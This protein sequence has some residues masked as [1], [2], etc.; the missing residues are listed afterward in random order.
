MSG[1]P[2]EAWK[3]IRIL[4]QGSFSHHCPL[5]DFTFCD[6]VTN[7]IAT[8]P[9]ANLRI[10]SDHVHRVHNCDDVP[11]HNEV[12]NDI[13]PRKTC[14]PIGD[15]PTYTEMTDSISEME[16]NKKLG[17]SGIPAKALQALP[18]A[19]LDMLY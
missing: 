10:L 18:P 5:S 14:H 12:I 9:A 3:A 6:P 15:T 2:R 16:N 7:S 4:Q 19:A 13:D 11:L 8:T 17:E 1:N